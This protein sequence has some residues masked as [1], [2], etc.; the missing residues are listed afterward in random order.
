VDAGIDYEERGPYELKGV[1]GARLLYAV[2]RS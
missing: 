1:S 2:L